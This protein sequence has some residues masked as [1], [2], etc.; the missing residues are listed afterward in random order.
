MTKR[1]ANDYVTRL[2]GVDMARRTPPLR[3]AHEDRGAKFTEF[4]GWDMPVEFDSIS[5]EHESVRESVGIFDVSHMGE[6]EVRG[7]DATE[8]MQRLTTNDVTNLSSGEGQ[9]SAIT[10]EKGIILDDTVV[11]S[12]PDTEDEYL[13]IPNAGHDDEMYARWTNYHD[14][15]EL[16]CEIEDATE[17]YAMFAVQGPDSEDSVA[18]AASDD[19]R[20]ITP[21][22]I[23][24]VTIEG[25]ECLASRT[26][27]T[28]EDGFE[29]IVPWDAAETVWKAFDCQPCG[30]GA[31]DTLRLEQGF[32]LSGQD[33]HPE[34]NPR[35][36]YG[37]GIGFVVSDTDFV[38][39]DELTE[40]ADP[41]EHLVGIAL[42]ER[43]IPRHGYDIVD[44]DENSIGTITSGTMSPTLGKPIG[45][46]Y[47]PTE[48][49]DPGTN[50]RVVVRGEQKAAHITQTPFEQ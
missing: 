46:G 41:D 49:A 8:L 23:D 4:G 20:E 1:E 43:G 17:Q 50:V 7:S 44:T 35:T 31:R 21:F 48:Y 24:T 12:L 3:D 34:G 26:G 27:Y 32:L 22:E 33:F 38:G 11:Y 36:P 28:G 10:D 40:R 19:V 2:M 18:G 13:F 45:L 15:W 42:T 14:E 30:L 29:L 6:I 9:Y 39:R 37:A 47:V 16:D 5:T 25:S